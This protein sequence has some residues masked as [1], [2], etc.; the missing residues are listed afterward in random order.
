MKDPL[1][2]EAVSFTHES[3]AGRHHEEAEEVKGE[4]RSSLDPAQFAVRRVSEVGEG[5]QTS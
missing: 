5:G 4:L 3:E 1:G 2:T